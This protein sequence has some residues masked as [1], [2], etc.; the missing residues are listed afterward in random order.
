MDLLAPD[1]ALLLADRY[2]RIRGDFSVLPSYADQNFR[3][4]T[5]SGDYV[6]KV[7]HPEWSRMD[8]DLE[9]QAMMALAE[10]E[11]AL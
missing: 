5:G 8:L 2:W 7:A 11:P 10:R 6:L 4:C 9:N 1:A 3:I